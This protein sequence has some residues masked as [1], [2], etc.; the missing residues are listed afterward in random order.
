MKDAVPFYFLV[1][2]WAVVYCVTCPLDA[3]AGDLVWDRET[4][5]MIMYSSFGVIFIVLLPLFVFGLC[6]WVRQLRSK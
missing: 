4:E 5:N 6:D 3:F 1:A 2:M